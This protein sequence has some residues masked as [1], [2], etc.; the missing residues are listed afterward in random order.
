MAQN[1]EVGP[2]DHLGLSSQSCRLGS[3]DHGQNKLH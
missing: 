3:G 1:R 2:R